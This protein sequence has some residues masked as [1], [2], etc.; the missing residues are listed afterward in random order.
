MSDLYPIQQ[1]RIHDAYSAFEIINLVG[2]AVPSSQIVVDPVL[3]QVARTTVEVVA[4][5]NA[6]GHVVTDAYAFYNTTFPALSN[7]FRAEVTLTRGA[8]VIWT[9]VVDQA[10]FDRNVVEDTIYAM[11]DSFY[12][13]SP[14]IQVGDVVKMVFYR[15]LQPEEQEEIQG[16]NNMFMGTGVFAQGDARY[17]TRHMFADGTTEAQVIAFFTA[18]AQRSYCKLISVMKSLTSDMENIPDSL[19]GN[20][21]KEKLLVQYEDK[22]SSI[23]EIPVAKKPIADLDTWFATNKASIVNQ[24]GSVAETIVKAEYPTQRRARGS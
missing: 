24:L 17:Y 16:E 6:A 11:I 18:L 1:L 13:T 3:G 9:Q 21:L 23:I 20:D 7:E 10:G 2:E 8:S 15:A 22:T 12:E 5:A 14:E 19:P 4:D